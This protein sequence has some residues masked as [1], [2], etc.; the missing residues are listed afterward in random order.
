MINEHKI[1]G[2]IEAIA[3][4]KHYKN[5]CE[6]II[7][8]IVRR[9]A[10]KYKSQKEIRKSAKGKLHQAFKS[11]RNSTSRK[12]RKA[13][14]DEISR[15][16]GLLSPEEY[17]DRILKQHVSTYERIDNYVN[18][19]KNI[20]T[21]IGKPKRIIDI[22][23]GLNPLAI[24]YMNNNEIE[25]YL[26]LDIDKENI[27]LINVIARKFDL[28]IEAV[29]CDV[30]LRDYSEEEFD[31]CF[32]FKFLPILEKNANLNSVY[33]LQRIKS[34]YFVVSYPLKSLRG[35]DKGMYEFY[36]SS[37]QKKI[38]GHYKILGENVYENELVYIIEAI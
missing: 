4:S 12:E 7:E 15:D 16:V 18:F 26:A 8:K 9:E 5:V 36:S 34:K 10:G 3:K 23:C 11:Y 31:A 32:V 28:P 22:A 21:F 38:D 37:F 19:Y 30:T 14:Y 6:D 20:A 1:N 29:A 35:R 24:Y 33:F 27:K 25:R 13:I 2:I 17:C